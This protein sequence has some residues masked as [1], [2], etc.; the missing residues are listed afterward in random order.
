MYK[1]WSNKLKK[2]HIHSIYE[3]W[4]NSNTPEQEKKST[5]REK[6]KN[7]LENYPLHS[8][9]NDFNMLLT[10]YPQSLMKLLLCEVYQWSSPSIQKDMVEIIPVQYI[11]SREKGLTYKGFCSPKYAEYIGNIKEYANEGKRKEA[12]NKIGGEYTEKHLM[13]STLTENYY[14]C[15][16]NMHILLPML[17]SVNNI[18][19]S[20]AFKNQLEKVKKEW[21][22]FNVFQYLENHSDDHLNEIS[23]G[24]QKMAST[25][26]N[27][28]KS[29]ELTFNQAIYSYF[30]KEFN[31]LS[32]T[33]EISDSIVRKLELM[34][35]MNSCFLAP[36]VEIQFNK[37]SE[38][39]KD[40]LRLNYNKTI[41]KMNNL[42]VKQ[43]NK[44]ILFI[45]ID[46]HING[47]GDSLELE[48]LTPVKEV[49]FNIKSL[50]LLSKINKMKAANERNVINVSQLE[51]DMVMLEDVIKE[52]VGSPNV[53]IQFSQNKREIEIA[54]KNDK[55]YGENDWVKMLGQI[56]M[57]MAKSENNEITSTFIRANM[58]SSIMIKENMERNEKLGVEVPG[59]KKLKF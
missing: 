4:D 39:Q 56:F 38:E 21:I 41:Y 27:L 12:E 33:H 18:E 14:K 34:S 55:Y 10:I 3:W 13:F 54:L 59:I 6:M 17:T 5:S 46:D 16:E 44:P 31:S 40:N 35:R 1:K 45:D 58:E 32:D 43:G 57:K 48:S 15:L 23:E 51:S 22:K 9:I 8:L 26:E 20:S 28:Q 7:V 47:D 19:V 36:M 42:L 11:S 25:K 2:A 24:W 53:K 50:E 29:E 30:L 49:R 52:V 37:L